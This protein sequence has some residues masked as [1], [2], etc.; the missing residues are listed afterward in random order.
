MVVALTPPVALLVVALFVAIVVLTRYVSL[1]S[2]LA[3]AAAGPIAFGLGAFQPGQLYLALALLIALK[4]AGNIRRLFTGVRGWDQAEAAR[5][6]RTRG[7]LPQRRG[8]E[9]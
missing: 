9:S 3:A 1:A 4:H 5:R 8:V 2:I 7:S 6:H